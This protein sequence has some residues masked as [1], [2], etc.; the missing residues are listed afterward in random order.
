MNI[1]ASV[2]TRGAV[3]PDPLSDSWGP[4]VPLDHIICRDTDGKGHPVS[5]FV[6]PWSAYTAGKTKA[7]LHFFYWSRGTRIRT[8]AKTDIA[9]HRLARIRE[10]QF[11]MT[12]LI[13][14]GSELSAKTLHARLDCLSYIARF[15]ESRSCSLLDV[16]T[17]QA[18]LDACTDG[19]P[20]RFIELWIAWLRFLGGLSSE[21]LGFTP[22]TP[23][24]ANRLLTRMR[25]VRQKRRQ[26]APL[27]T[28][29][30]AALITNLSAQLAEFE[31]IKASLLTTLRSALALY[32]KHDGSIP[33]AA[34]IASRVIV[35]PTV[36]EFLEKRG[37]KSNRIGSL[38]AVISDLFMLCKLQ[39][40]VFTGMRDSE[41]RQL[42]FHCMETES[43]PQG[44]NYCIVVGNT[45][46]L[47]RGRRLRT[48][49]VTT[50]ADGFRA[51][52]LAQEFASVIYEGLDQK[53]R[54]SDLHRDDYPLFPSTDY[55]PWMRHHDHPTAQ[56]PYAPH[57]IYLGHAGREGNL[58]SSLCPEITTEDIQELE[59]ID[60]FRAWRSE[61]EFSVGRRW[62]L[63]THQLRRSLAIYA[64]AS[65]LVRSSSLRRQLQHVAQAMTAYYTRG[66][67]FC[68]D[69]V[70]R[71]PA[72]Y[73]EHI[74]VDWQD[75]SEESEMLAFVR[76][77]LASP[78]RLFG[79]AGEYYQRARERGEVMSR[80]EVSKQ[81]KAGLL[82]YSETPFGA[83]T[84]V[85]GCDA[86]KGL[87]LLDTVCATAGC[88]NLIGKHSKVVELVRL[89]R[90]AMSRV[91]D[92]SINQ[93]IDLEDLRSL[94]R[95]ERSWRPTQDPGL[96]SEDTRAQHH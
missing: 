31:S 89:K 1:Q 59:H 86:R 80:D 92:G 8:L 38:S 23:T 2:D 91:G 77:V 94:E 33:G 70:K 10:L 43:G 4:R 75:G 66:S 96:V 60:P 26:F 95:L 57:S 49:W 11:L 29:V 30:Y 5:S 81:L 71:D 39:I 69:F 85:G 20:T 12:R 7:A 28:R 76:D 78:E 63:S 41:A 51:I 44:R 34:S 48:K 47:N 35:D 56:S 83:C 53:P 58:V 25:L 82:S 15:A 93:M 36:V 54:S 62:P 67:S 22:A 6:W 88:R 61:A 45:T 52:R 74:A 18:L 17:K 72:G 68:R 46:K 19:I 9:P 24:H 73:K 50:E 84:R 14:F 90:A 79:P 13:Y 27:P 55:L 64:N 65:G 42:P 32:R 37:C 40:H 3:G 21:A 16:L 87:N